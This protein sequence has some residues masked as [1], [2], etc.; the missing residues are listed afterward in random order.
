MQSAWDGIEVPGP[1]QHGICNPTL[2]MKSW[3]TAWRALTKAIACPAC[4]LV[5]N[6]GVLCRKKSCKTDISKLQSKLNGFRFHD[7]RHSAI[8]EL[9]E[10]A[11]ASEQTIL[12]IAGHVSRKMLEH[13]SHIRNEA[14]RKA[15]DALA[16]P[17]ETAAQTAHEPAP[18]KSKSKSSAQS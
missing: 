17:G 16:K 11:E 14:K 9:A 1:H 5:Q 7:M 6:P 18:T 2:P 13:Y 4:G 3:R 15:L 8:T 12:S 10:S